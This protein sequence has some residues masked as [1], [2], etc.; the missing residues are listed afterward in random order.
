VRDKIC[1]FLGVV[2]VLMLG[3]C[4]PN[5]PLPETLYSKDILP[6]GLDG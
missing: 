1:L 4:M 2:L 6:S 5:D 3:G